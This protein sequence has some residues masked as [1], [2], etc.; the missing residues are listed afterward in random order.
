MI[1]LYD[2]LVTFYELF[3]SKATLGQLPSQISA[4]VALASLTSPLESPLKEL[5]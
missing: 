5:S 2:G 3:T 1:K 4:A